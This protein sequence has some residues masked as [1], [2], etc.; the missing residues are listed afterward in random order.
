MVFL[1]FHHVLAHGFDDAFTADGRAY[2]HDGAAQNHE[3]DRNHHTGHAGLAVAERHAEEQHA[4]ELLAVLRAMHEAHGR[5]AH[6]L[7][8]G[9]EPVGA[10]AV[11]ASAN[12]GHG[13]AYQPADG[14]AEQEACDQTVEHLDPFAHVDAADAAL[15][16]DG[17]SGQAGD[18][19]VAFGGGYAEQRGAHAVYDDGEQRRA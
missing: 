5:R 4:D 1:E 10:A 7:R 19:A 2:A 12:Q 9:E 15:D 13:L 11:H 17:R 16:G 6:D 8:V 3:P 18:Q 14:K